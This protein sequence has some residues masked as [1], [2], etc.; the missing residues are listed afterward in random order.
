MNETIYWMELLFKTD[1]ISE[2][3]F[4]SLH[5][6]AVEMLKLL[7]SSIKTKKRNIGLL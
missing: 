4:E 5:T 6:D 7:T 1:F 3:E 2:K